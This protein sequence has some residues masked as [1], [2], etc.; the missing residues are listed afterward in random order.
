MSHTTTKKNWH[1]RPANT[2][3]SV[4]A[5]PSDLGI[6]CPHRGSLDHCLSCKRTAKILISLGGCQG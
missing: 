1:V 5:R 2:Q 6:R 4:C 3:N